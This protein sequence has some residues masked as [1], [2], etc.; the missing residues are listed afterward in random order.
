MDSNYFARDFSQ[1]TLENYFLFSVVKLIK[2]IISTL[3]SSIIFLRYLRARN[4][5]FKRIDIPGP[6]PTILFGN[7]S[8]IR[9]KVT[10]EVF[11]R[12]TKQFGK[13]YGYY[14]F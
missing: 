13:V 10:A 7:L 4:D 5:I 2:L 14:L 3:I 1:Y 11:R 6:T 12:W 8:E 9:N